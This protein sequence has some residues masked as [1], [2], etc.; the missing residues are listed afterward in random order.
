MKKAQGGTG[1]NQ[2]KQIRQFDGSAPTAEALA[3]EH[4]VSERT[5]ERDDQFAAAVEAVKAIKRNGHRR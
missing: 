1:A 4:G 5:I 3:K 2:H